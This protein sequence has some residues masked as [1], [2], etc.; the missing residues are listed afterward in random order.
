MAIFIRVFRFLGFFLTD[1][2]SSKKFGLC[3]KTFYLC[4]GFKKDWFYE[5]RGKAA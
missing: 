3:A 4:S 1:L 2:I 5:Y